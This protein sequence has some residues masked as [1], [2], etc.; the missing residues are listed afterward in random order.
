MILCLCGRFLLISFSSTSHHTH[1]TW[2]HKLRTLRTLNKLPQ[3]SAVGQF[4]NV[5][6]VH[7]K[8]R[9]NWFHYLPLEVHF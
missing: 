6:L 3:L 5:Y 9:C 1:V 4:V 7:D 8:Y 2:Q